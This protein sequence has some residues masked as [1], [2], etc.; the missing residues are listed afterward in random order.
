MSVWSRVCDRLDPLFATLHA[1]DE[2]AMEAFSGAQ[3]LRKLYRLFVAATY[4]GDGYVWAALATGLAVFGTTAD[5]WNVVVGF[6]VTVANLVLVRLLKMAVSRERPEADGEGFRGRVID[7]F[8]F[9]SGHATTS[10]GLAYLVAVRYPHPAV[11]AAVCLGATTIALSRVYL[12][13]HYFLDIAG[14]AV[15]GTL[16][17]ASLLPLFHWLV[18]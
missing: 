4:L 17:A 10:F 14:G 18:F 2:R 8:S 13:E 5:R 16:V 7:T 9:P 11:Q 12:R 3:A 6:G 1:W 15:L